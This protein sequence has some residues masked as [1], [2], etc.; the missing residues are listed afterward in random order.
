MVD[1]VNYATALVIGAII[2]II[3]SRCLASAL[4]NFQ[5]GMVPRYISG[6]RQG[7]VPS[8]FEDIIPSGSIRDGAFLPTNF[9]SQLELEDG[10]SLDRYRQIVKYPDQLGYTQSAAMS[11]GWA[12]GTLVNDKPVV[13]YPNWHGGEYGGWPRSTMGYPSAYPSWPGWFAT[14]EQNMPSIVNY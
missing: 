1:T 8:R 11:L 13:Q 4:Y 2:G 5:Q 12:G 9:N 3:L 10:N 14:A 6:L 7:L